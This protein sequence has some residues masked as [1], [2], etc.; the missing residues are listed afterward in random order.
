LKKENCEF[1]H[2]RSQRNFQAVPRGRH[3]PAQLDPARLD[4]WT[5][6]QR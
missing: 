2:V 1:P 3:L 6:G 5:V 4:R